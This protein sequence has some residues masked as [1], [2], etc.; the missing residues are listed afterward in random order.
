MSTNV[1][2]HNILFRIIR[3]RNFK[4]DMSEFKIRNLKSCRNKKCSKIVNSTD[5]AE[6]RNLKVV[7]MVIKEIC[8]C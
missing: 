1:L 3:N 6:C 4:F 7:T 8:K 5:A 2:K